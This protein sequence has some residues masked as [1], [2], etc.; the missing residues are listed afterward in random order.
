VQ[1]LALLYKDFSLAGSFYQDFV[2][3]AQLLAQFEDPAGKQ[4]LARSLE[5]ESLVR[6][7]LH[8]MLLT[9]A[10]TNIDGVP[11][12]LLTQQL[13]EH[14]A[15]F[16]GAVST[17][18]HS[19]VARK[20][21]EEHERLLQGYGLSR[22]YLTLQQFNAPDLVALSGLLVSVFTRGVECEAVNELWQ[23]FVGASQVRCTQ[24]AFA[25]TAQPVPGMLD[26][27]T[28]VE[29]V[30]KIN[31]RCRDRQIL[32]PLLR[33][34]RARWHAAA[35]NLLYTRAETHG[36]VMQEKVPVIPLVALPSADGDICLVQPLLQRAQGDFKQVPQYDLFDVSCDAKKGEGW[37]MYDDKLYLHAWDTVKSSHGGVYAYGHELSSQ[38][39]ESQ[40]ARSAIVSNLY[41]SFAQQ[42]GADKVL[43]PEQ[44]SRMLVHKKESLDANIENW[45]SQASKNGEMPGNAPLPK[46]LKRGGES[47]KVYA[48][49]EE[50]KPGIKLY[51]R[52]IATIDMVIKDLEADFALR[53]NNRADFAAHVRMTECITLP[54]LFGLFSAE[55]LFD[56]YNDVEPFI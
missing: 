33:L 53:K 13:Q 36:L 6:L 44:L 54:W 39:I 22:E 56:D 49:S 51:L 17:Y 20:M 10:T 50:Q 12:G 52:L 31:P 25:L 42:Y 41:T 3:N 26:D 32:L 28:M 18:T 35:T 19:A 34:V 55:P 43:P 21:N 27:G 11:L 24:P 4:Q 9:H 46:A 14:I 40:G 8:D 1:Q 5:Q 2:H 45:Q 23:S 47:P 30:A 7:A 29:I 15:G 38:P 48:M 16:E 37:R